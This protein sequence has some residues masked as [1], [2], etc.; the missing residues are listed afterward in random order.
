MPHLKVQVTLRNKNGNPDDLYV[1][2]FHFAGDASDAN[3]VENLVYDFYNDPA[4]GQAASLSAHLSA[5]IERG[6]GGPNAPRIAVYEIPD[7]PPYVSGPPVSDTP[8]AL[9]SAA[10]SAILPAELAV[11]LSFYAGDPRPNRRGR[12]YFGPL[13]AGSTGTIINGDQR[14]SSTLMNRLVLAAERLMDDSAL[15]A[16]PWGVFGKS[17]VLGGIKVLRTVTAGWAD[18]AFDIQRRRGSVATTRSVFP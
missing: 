10:G 3:T 14:V 5:E 6:S 9:P 16:V 7:G 1:N 15:A 13:D 12:I 11:V 17:D 4:P 18:N 8:V 2:T